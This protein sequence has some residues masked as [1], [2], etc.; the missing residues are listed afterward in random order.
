M[1]L[2]V[3]VRFIYDDVGTS[4]IAKE[5]K[6]AFN[7]AGVQHYPFM[8]VYIPQL[9]KANFRDHRKIVVIDGKIGYTGGINVADRYI[10]QGSQ[11]YWRDTHLKVTGEAV[12][13]LQ[14]IFMLNWYF[15]SKESLPMNDTYFPALPEIGKQCM[16]VVA[17]G[18]DSDWASIMQAFFLAIATAKKK[19]QIT[20]PYFIPNESILTALKTVA[21]GGVKVELMYP[22]VSDSTIVQAASMSYMREIL[23]AGVKI[24]LY[25]KGFIHAKTIVVDG[26]LSSVG[27]ANMDYRSFDQNFEVNAMIYDE[28]IA[29]QLSD[30]FEEDKKQ[31]VPLQLSRWQQRP[32]RK[33]LVES[34][35]R[36]LAPLL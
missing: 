18:P 26:I 21:M 19:I 2:S 36:L 28:G 35:S 32:I 7:T 9:S 8:P 17:S 34:V 23:E 27:T 13:S 12:R 15:V 29:H 22:Y 20:S 5:F 31:C 1:N 25:T 10:N 16:Q 24:H 3:E 33:R 30:Q 6:Q 14:I 11:K 4:H